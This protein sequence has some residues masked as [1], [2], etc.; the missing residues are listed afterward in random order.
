MVA[1]LCREVGATVTHHD[2]VKAPKFCMTE[3]VIKPHWHG[4]RLAD[5]Q[6][7][8]GMMKDAPEEFIPIN[9][10]GTCYLGPKVDIVIK[11]KGPTEDFQEEL[12]EFLEQ[13]H[14]NTRNTRAIGSTQEDDVVER[15]QMHT[16]ACRLHGKCTH[17]PGVHLGEVF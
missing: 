14:K 2:V 17:E 9:R 16:A 10:A 13:M 5:I 1:V 15:H 8:D 7:F 6:Y 12:A 3:D 4:N 11:G